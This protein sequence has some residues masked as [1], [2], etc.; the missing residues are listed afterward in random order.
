VTD[1]Y[2]TEPRL[3]PTALRR[4]TAEVVPLP[5]RPSAPKIAPQI[6]PAAMPPYRQVAAKP[7]YHPRLFGKQAARAP[8]GTRVFAI[9]DI[10][11]R[12]DLLQALL[13]EIA[14]DCADR[15]CAGKPA[16]VFIGDYIDRGVQSRDVIDQVLAISP[17][18]FDVFCLRGNHESELLTF[19]EHPE[20]GAR[21]MN[22]G[23]RETLY[24][25][26]VKAPGPAPSDMQRAARDL[27]AAMPEA[28]LNFLRSLKLYVQLGDYLFVHAGLRP[29]RPL[30]RQS[31]IDLLEIRD[32]FLNSKQRWP[33]VVVHG[34]C[35]VPKA[36]VERGRISL[37]TGAYATGKLSAVRLEG[38]NIAFLS[39]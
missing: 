27:C 13:A 3:I 10:H 31:E 33:F 19:L 8:A 22:L 14:Q 32:P 36:A 11:G 2:Q 30:S 26:G 38:D 12:A 25:Y 16:I 29:G 15:P 21:W 18:A 23:G 5:A 39:I 35:P 20:T 17:S 7:I 6:A 28:H 4:P 37:D 1:T 9:G 34:H 24:S